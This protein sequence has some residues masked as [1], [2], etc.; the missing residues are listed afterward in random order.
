VDSRGAGGGR[1][2]AP[3]VDRVQCPFARK[4]CNA[5]EAEQLNQ[6]AGK[7]ANLRERSA[8]LRRYL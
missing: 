7:I 1:P 5:M 6:I 4:R 3:G 8:D 2:Q